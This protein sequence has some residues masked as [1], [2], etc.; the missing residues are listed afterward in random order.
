M[1]KKSRLLAILLIPFLAGCD[2]KNSEPVKPNPDIDDN[3]PVVPD[4]KPG[5]DP[6]KEPVK[7]LT[8]YSINDSHGD[9]LRDPDVESYGFDGLKYLMDN[10]TKTKGYEDVVYLCTGDM[11]QGQYVSNNTRGKAV[12]DALNYIDLDAFVLGNH[13]FDWG[14]DQIK[15]FKDG[16]EENGELNCDILCANLRYKPTNS[17]PDWIKPYTIVEKAGHK[18]GIIGFMGEGL[19]SSIL[20]EMVEDYEFIETSTLANQYARELR[21]E[22][23]CD[24]V[25]IGIHDY[26]INTFIDFSNQETPIDGIFGGHT[27]AFKLDDFNRRFDSK[28][29]YSIQSGANNEGFSVINMKY[30]EDKTLNS[31]DAYSIH[32]KYSGN[33]VDVKLKEMIE[34]KY[35]TVIAQ[36]N[37]VI[38][39]KFPGKSRYEWGKYVSSALIGKYSEGANVGL[40]NKGG[41]RNSTDY[42]NSDG[43]LYAKQLFRVLPFDNKIYQVE[44]PRSAL[45]RLL[46][47]SNKY[48]YWAK[49]NDIPSGDTYILNII[50]YVFDGAYDRDIFDQARIIKTFDLNIR[51]YVTK[52][53]KG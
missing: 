29:I 34:N 3:V 36:G 47:S 41:I 24:T 42:R 43:K 25:V 30:N 15:L 14:L 45:D 35:A 17:L 51:D 48:H 27:H 37:E 19:E 44:I 46:S 7:D 26:D 4:D 33:D 2:N 28:K 1:I 10:E 40:I 22:K 21:E 53:I 49:K 8:F 6:N 23:G 18:V 13:E 38:S 31:T 12:V 39:E 9:L 20:A 52:S 5:T 50:D 16:I 11:F 32:N